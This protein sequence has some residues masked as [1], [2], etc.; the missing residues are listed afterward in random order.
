MEGT[1]E[2]PCQRGNNEHGDDLKA[3]LGQ[4]GPRRLAVKLDRGAANE[5][6]RSAPS[7]AFHALSSV[8]ATDDVSRWHHHDE[9]LDALSLLAVTFGLSSA[10]L[11]AH[12]LLSYGEAVA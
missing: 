11:V 4:L 5:K 7:H 12:L 1:A 9:R 8:P 10:D 6:L 2:R 3:D